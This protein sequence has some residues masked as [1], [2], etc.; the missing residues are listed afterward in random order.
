MSDDLENIIRKRYPHGDRYHLNRETL[1]DIMKEARQQRDKDVP[2]VRLN[3]CAP[4]LP[5]ECEVE[6][7]LDEVRIKRMRP[8]TG[9]FM[10]PII[11]INPKFTPKER[12]D[13]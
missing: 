3:T 8:I 5:D 4:R 13:V 2:V 10:V 6:I 9:G 7:F 11:A 12:T 1:I